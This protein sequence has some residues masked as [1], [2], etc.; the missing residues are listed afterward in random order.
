MSRRAPASSPASPT[1]TTIA[2][3]AAETSGRPRRRRGRRGGRRGRDRD[4]APRDQT[5]EL[6]ARP[7][8]ESGNGAGA[9]ED[10]EPAARRRPL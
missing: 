1:A 6:G 5:D 3:A 2:K 10:R 4:E 8:E 9:H 7:A